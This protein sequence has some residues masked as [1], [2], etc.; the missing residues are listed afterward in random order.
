MFGGFS[1]ISAK[2]YAA[3][4]SAIGKGSGRGGR[5]VPSYPSHYK[6]NEQKF[7]CVGPDCEKAKGKKR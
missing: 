2:E 5:S 7:P 3:R 4:S 6:G 1:G